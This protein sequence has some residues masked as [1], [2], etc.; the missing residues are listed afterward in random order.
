VVEGKRNCRVILGSIYFASGIILALMKTRLIPI[1]LLGLISVLLVGLG[2]YTRKALTEAKIVVEWSTASELNTVGFNLF[3]SQTEADPGVLVNA[4]LIP[5]SEDAQTGGEY[6]YT[7]TN[8]VPGQVYYY[9]LEDVS[10]G[11][12]TKIHGP[13]IV[14][15]QANGKLEWFLIIVFTVIILFG[16]LTLLWPRRKTRE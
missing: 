12:E 13:V 15:A 8:V 2:V 16:L 5:A 3:R 9:Y 10:A 1:I 7:D 6:R 11:G 4:E 14:K